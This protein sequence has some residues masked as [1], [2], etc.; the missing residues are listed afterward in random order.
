MIGSCSGR[1]GGAGLMTV[2]VLAAV[3]L[4]CALG[5]PCAA[6]QPA[7]N[8]AAPAAVAAPRTPA[9]AAV[10]QD[11]P[12]PAADLAAAQAA[13]DQLAN[14]SAVVSND[15]RLAAMAAGAAR[16]EAQ[17]R[18]LAAERARR[19]EAIDAQLAKIVPH[20]RRA[21]TAAQRARQAP[22]VA[23]R[24]TLQREF[25]AA[26]QVAG[27][28]QGA[29]NRIAER[30]REGFSARVLT[31]SPS[32]LSPAFWT[33]V[34]AEAS[35]DGARLQ[36]MAQDAGQVIA[37]AD[38][39]RAGIAFVAAAL[40]GAALLLLIRP[41]LERLGRRKAAVG[42]RPA[43]LA[44]TAAAL[45]SAA[46]DI[47]A[48][49]LA[50]A[51]LRFTAEWAGLLSPQAD[52][53][54]IAAV[55]AT[56]WS[57]GIVALG[58][59]LA[60]D[61]DPDLRLLDLSDEDARRVRTPLLIVGIVTGAGFMLSRLNYVIGASVAATIAANC[62]LSLAY[63]GTATLFLVSFGRGRAPT[64]GEAVGTADARRDSVWTLI[65]LALSAA[66]VVTLGA[67]F[68]GYTTLAALTSGQ[69]FWL[70]LL[71]A[72]AYLVMRFVDD[73]TS[74][75]FR[76][77]GWAARTLFALFR[78]RRSTI[79]Q[80]GALVSAASQVLVAIGVLTLAL[81]PF[82]QGGE[83]L[84]THLAQL[85]APIR[86]GSATISPGAVA[87]GIVTFLVGL[88]LAR[89]VQGWV[90]RRYLPVTDWDVGVRNSV[91]TGVGYIGV[92]L[93]VACALAA[94]GLGFAQIALIASALSVGIGFGLQTIVQNF[95]S[96]IILLVERPVKVGDWI[97]IAGVEGGVRRIRVRATEIET[98]DRTTVIVPNSDLV[99][100]Q[101]ANKMLDGGRRAR[102]DIR[103]SV[104]QPADV[105]RARELIAGVVGARQGPPRVACGDPQP[106]I[107]IDSLAAGGAVNL[108][109]S[110][111]V[112]EARLAY[113]ARSDCYTQI[114]RALQDNKI[115][116]A[117]PA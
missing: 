11:A 106:E 9:P 51:V 36:G 101:V 17:T 108:T 3:A 102:I 23:Q 69:M 84:F 16:I 63:A 29:Y 68:A 70:G 86:I 21:P 49:T 2:A 24:A 58:D 6:A 55:A 87:A 8:A 89:M 112:D 46:L 25:A 82:G 73:L 14:Q 60:A 103:L 10:P 34:A 53:L 105:E 94:S 114:L 72:A 56:A 43:G 7:A 88:G 37:T 85:G 27:Q 77:R 117:G 26:E 39:P 15:S 38:E 78:F 110:F 115:A 18:G 100:K 1:R 65:S 35:D 44:K 79:A 116:F 75:I 42:P 113:R 66:I 54:A 109:C 74:A 52:A 32:P 62:V 93:A 50:V 80:I 95:V 20:S 48:P 47:A 33:S 76:P 19:I 45:W 104:T 107:Y 64:A 91:T 28:A 97:S 57:A 83:L 30:R 98:Q 4:A 90:V 41:R 22:L 5:R 12:P 59:V 96:G 71:G 31:R 67:V 61:P 99:T 40:A 92:M 81:T 13:L 111:F